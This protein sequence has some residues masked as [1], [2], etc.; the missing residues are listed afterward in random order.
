MAAIISWDN[1]VDDATITN[2]TS[3]TS[4][5]INTEVI[6]FATKLKTRQLGDIGRQN[7]TTTP[8][9]LQQLILDFNLGSAKSTQLIAILNHNMQG[10][11]YTIS[12]GTSLGDNSVGTETGTFFNGV[13]ADSPNDFLYF[14]SAYSAQFVR[15]AV[16][17]TSA[18]TIDIGRV[19]M[20][21]ATAWAIKPDLLSF[22][23]G[24][25]DTST[26]AES[27]GG[28]F[29]STT[30]KRRRVMQARLHG[31]DTDTLIGDSTDTDLKSFMTLD[32]T[33]GTSGEVI[34]MGDTT[35]QIT[36]QRLSIYGHISR[37]EPIQFREKN[38]T[39]GY[40]SEKRFTILEDF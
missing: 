31:E 20:D 18:T 36:K 6:S 40:I 8:S 9:P 38:P 19:W 27:R 14:S 26:S 30:R 39:D 35:N 33:V 13:S 12:F 29:Y 3:V 32:M 16:V 7:F 22:A 1:Y 2:S 34:M 17:I 23:I 37:N 5:L 11:A 24:I 25:Q 10:L 4:P 28:S 15:I 21:G